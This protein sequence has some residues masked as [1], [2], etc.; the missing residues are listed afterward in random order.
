LWFAVFGWSL[1]S[2]LLV[3][4]QQWGPGVACW[5]AS[6][7][8]TWRTGHPTFRRRMGVLLISV[9]ILAITQ[10]D[11]DL[12]NE[13]FVVLGAVLGGLAIAPRLLLRS[14][15]PGI[16]DNHWWT[17]RRRV[18][19]AVYIALAVPV[20]WAALKLYFVVNPEVAGN[21]VLPPTPDREALWRLFLGINGVGMW[22]ELFLVNVGF[23]LLRSMLSFPLANL[24]QASL[25]TAVLY[26]MA[27]TGWG[28]LFVYPFALTQGLLYERSRSLLNIIVVH[29]IMD[30]FLF[31]EIVT[32]YYPGQSP[33]GLLFGG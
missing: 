12:S 22:E 13:H 20:A 6:A 5:C 14:T 15:D 33:V 28:P 3:A 17:G 9:A 30:W 2:V 16:L 18:L 7:I 25:Y 1:A 11:T 31:D 27:F 32:A 29:L 21:W 19:Q 4:L 23:V 24:A 10:I 8:I 26:N